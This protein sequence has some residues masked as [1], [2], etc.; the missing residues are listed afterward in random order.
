MANLAF[1]CRDCQLDFDSRFPDGS[2]PE[3]YSADAVEKRPVVA[4]GNPAQPIGAPGTRPS[5]AAPVPR[6]PDIPPTIFP[7]VPRP[8]IRPPTGMGLGS[9]PARFP[10]A[11][12]GPPAA[13]R[14]K[15][16]KA[17]RMRAP[18]AVPGPLPSRVFVNSV[19]APA[20]GMLQQDPALGG[21]RVLAKQL[22]DTAVLG[23]GRPDA[24]AQFFTATDQLGAEVL[25]T[26]TVCSNPITLTAYA[27]LLQNAAQIMDTIKQQAEERLKALNMN[28]TLHEAAFGRKPAQ[29][30][31]N[32]PSSS[33]AHF[34]HPQ[35]ITTTL[36]V[37]KLPPHAKEH[38]LYGYFVQFCTPVSA[39]QTIR[40]A[41]NRQ[42]RECRGFAV[43]EFAGADAVQ[44]I[45]SRKVHAIH[46]PGAP[47][48]SGV[49]VYSVQV[50][51]F[52]RTVQQKKAL[53][54]L[55]YALFVRGLSSF[56]QEDDFSRLVSEKYGRVKDLFFQ[57]DYSSPSTKNAYA[58]ITF[59][60]P[61]MNRQLLDLG[62]IEIN[63][64]QLQCQPCADPRKHGKP[65]ASGRNTAQSDRIEEPDTA[66]NKP[67]ADDDDRGK[68]IVCSDEDIRI[69][70]I[71]CNHICVCQ[72]CSE[73]ME[74]CPYCREPIT[75][76]NV[77]YV[78]Q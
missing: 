23:T 15:A 75:Q 34:P 56:M 25:A 74:E 48:G 6:Q 4:Q 44:R 43:M 35:L 55:E 14:V 41:R 36:M 70:F 77:V 54:N 58:K 37:K 61:E 20:P 22:L 63:G 12:R 7:N 24:V 53:K 30:L 33:G 69:L 60:D 38:H 11:P 17:S 49:W 32:Y 66:G 65:A 16:P 8:S 10:P 71:P 47:D 9:A 13:P 50:E 73:N 52:D 42:T 21:A 62:T 27:N 68:C 72:A 46:M 40:I 39:I 18:G 31:P 5:S 3:C 59:E 1:H 57:A 78:V 29:N 67:V 51:P 64:R 26:L 76:K 19:V 2:C 28:V 45:C